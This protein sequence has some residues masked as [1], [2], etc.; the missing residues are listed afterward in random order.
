MIRLTVNAHSDPEIHLFN[1]PTILLGSDSSLVDLTLPGSDIQPIHL[2]ILYQ[3]G[4][5]ILINYAND[6]FVSVNGHPFGK[7][8]LNSGDVILVQQITILFEYLISEID[9]ANKDTLASLIDH[10]TFN[11][12]EIL[13][14]SASPIEAPYFSSFALPFEQEVET[15]K[16]EELQK[17]SLETYLKGLEPV[18]ET[19]KVT[20]TSSTNQ[21]Q[22]SGKRK[23]GKSLKDDYLGDLEDDHQGEV[24]PS[25]LKEPSHLFLAWKRILLFIFSLFAVAGVL[26]TVVYFSVTDKK[27]RQEI[28]AAQGMA[29][30]AMALT[31]AQLSHLNPHNQNWSD[32]E[33]LKNNLQAILP[34]TSSYAAQ[35]DAQGQ[36]KS[37][38]YSLRIYTNRDLS[39]FLLIAQPAPSFLYWL[40]PQSIM[41][42]DSHL[43]EL[44]TLKDVKSL[45]R[46]L[47]NADPL[48]GINGKEITNLVKQGDL[49]RLANLAADSG[50]LDFSPPKNLAWLRPGAENFIYNAPRYYRLG[51][52]IL[53]KAISLSTEKGSSQ[54]V[55]HLKQEVESLNW[56]NHFI[57]Y[58]DQ[59]RK[60]ALLARQG[61][62]TFAPS[63]KVLFGYLL[64]N[65]QG[66]IHQ[67]YLLKE[68]EERRESEIVKNEEKE[69]N[70]IAFQSPEEKP[71]TSKAAGESLVDRNHPLYIQLQ[72]LIMAR[73]NELKPLIADLTN[74]INQDLLVP[75]SP[76]FDIEFQKLSHSYLTAN[77]KHKQIIKENLDVL[78]HQYDEMPFEQFLAFIKELHLDQLIQQEEQALTILHDNCQH[79]IANLLTQIEQ[80][81]SLA[82]LNNLV[83]IAKS[84]LCLDYI[85]DPQ[86][87]IAYQ[88]SLRNQTLE[89]LEKYLLSEQK[90]S[91]VKPED[92]ESLL[93]LLNQEQLIRAEERDFFLK[94][95]EEQ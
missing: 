21:T 27:D 92:K 18:E 60:S 70:L 6:P 89:Q 55:T 75:H 38:P 47:A 65:A 68:E 94:E 64:F 86:E 35:I 80:S 30:I 10:K 12:E 31:H 49:I 73:E 23:Q 44:H 26:G 58:S 61:L 7:K 54:E 83:H 14:A 9:Q 95:F 3:N 91:L 90:H 1:K 59:G 19:A 32:A 13:P 52:R 5:P 78:Y 16:E 63:D 53:Q 71:E 43:M 17:S 50:H 48:E 42:V 22:I 88:N 56:L 84:W 11:P 33:F 76:Q 15:L 51:Q 39:H 69:E 25:Q 87:L 45:N 81:K 62:L 82:E 36:F 20:S 41:V 67:V 85:K 24:N 77:Q 74:L 66:K 34:D 93:S 8:L 29:D 40:I 46:L 4:F 28:K 72:L 57:L 79:I 2:Q 37:F